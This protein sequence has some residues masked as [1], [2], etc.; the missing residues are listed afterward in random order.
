MKKTTSAT[1]LLTVALTVLLCELPVCFS[2]D[3]TVSYQLLDPVNSSTEYRL[4]IIIPQSLF[5]Y[6]VA[7][8]HR[9]FSEADFAKFVTPYS[10]KPIADSLQEIYTDDEDFA[11]GVLMIVHQIPYETTTPSKY[12]VETMIANKGDCDLFSYIAASILKARGLNVVL[13]Y[14]EQEAHMNIGISLSHEPY[15]ARQQIYYVKYQEVKYYVA[16]C[17]GGNW[18]SGWRVGECPD[19]L[20]NANPQV[21]TL[22]NCEQTATGQVSAS[23]KTL[24]PSTLTLVA[25]SA[26]VMQG[27]TVTLSGQ[28][29][30]RLQG[31]NITIYVRANSS[32]WKVLGIATTA[33]D[34]HYQYE[35]SVSEAGF[36]SVRASWSGNDEYAVVDSPVRSVT[37][38]SIFFVLL[39]A[40]TI[41]MVIVG[42]IAY[43]ATRHTTP[44]AQELGF[45]E[46]TL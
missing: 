16:E 26:F 13:L 45:S 22:E 32:P 9:T 35:W 21:I 24:L 36:C 44:D 1:F 37:S 31:E 15:D 30:P 43:V 8:D 11:N 14:Y 42:V 33:Q 39:I 5:E 27:S 28:L 25:S 4:N 2:A 12:P 18:K 23:Y 38:L 19:E 34:G 41:I 40:I 7:K 46:P 20:K 29:T 17:T 6:Y 10:L 3:Y